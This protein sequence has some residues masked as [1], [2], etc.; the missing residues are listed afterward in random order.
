MHAVAELAGLEREH[1]TELAAAEHADRGTG[2]EKGRV[3]HYVCGNSLRV[4]AGEPV[5]SA[6]SSFMDRVVSFLALAVLG[7]LRALPLTACFAL[8]Q[9]VGAVM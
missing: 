9:L 8:G 6:L 7:L 3:W 5:G 1:A 4:R 2:R